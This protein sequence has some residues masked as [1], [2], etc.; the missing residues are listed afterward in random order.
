[1]YGDS[2]AA[3]D[4]AIVMAELKNPILPGHDLEAVAAPVRV[5]V[6]S[7]GDRYV[8]LSGTEVLL[9]PGDMMMADGVGSSAGRT[10][11]PHH[12]TD[13]E[14]PVRRLRAGRCRRGRGQKKAEPR[15]IER[16]TDLGSYAGEPRTRRP[17]SA[18]LKPG[19]EGRAW[20]PRPSG[21]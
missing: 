21:R 8:L 9:A 2:R 17:S 12:S 5:S 10:G 4:E 18:L 16:A 20:S 13:T 15:P 19:W 7:E 3:L 14:P 6:T 1:M 11:G